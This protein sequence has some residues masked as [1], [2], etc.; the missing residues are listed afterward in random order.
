MNNQ[1]TPPQE[2]TPR[3]QKAQCFYSKI[4]IGEIIVFIILMVFAIYIEFSLNRTTSIIM[5]W[6]FIFAFLGLSIL[7]YMFTWYYLRIDPNG[8]TIFYRFHYKRIE[9]TEIMQITAKMKHQ[10]QQETN[11]FTGIGV[12]V[13]YP[14][15]FRTG[16]VQLWIYTPE[17]CIKTPKQALRFKAINRFLHH[18]INLHKYSIQRID[19]EANERG[20]LYYYINWEIKSSNSIFKQLSLNNQSYLY[21]RNNSGEELNQSLSWTYKLALVVFFLAFID[22]LF[23]IYIFVLKEYDIFSLLMLLFSGSGMVFISIL[24]SIYSPEVRKTQNYQPIYQI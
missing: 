22:L 8:L 7:V 11:A 6:F 17:D 10:K 16:A 2:F 19:N 12:V 23:V 1:T 24:L 4:A 3:N 20:H 9:W 18:I 21:L 14:Y 13:F 15:I 5:I